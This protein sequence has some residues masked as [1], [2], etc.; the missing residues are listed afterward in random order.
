MCGLLLALQLQHLDLYFNV[1]LPSAP[2]QDDGSLAVESS[3]NC[4]QQLTYL[5]LDVPNL[6]VN[7]ST[8]P[9]PCN[10]PDLQHLDLRR[11]TWDPQ[12]LCTMSKLQDLSLDDLKV[13]T[14]AALSGSVGLQQLTQLVLGLSGLG[15]LSATACAALTASSC[16]HVV[17][18]SCSMPDGAWQ[19]IFAAGRSKPFLTKL[20]LCSRACPIGEDLCSLVQCCPALAELYLGRYGR[21]PGISLS[22]L[23]ALTS[24]THLSTVDNAVSEQSVCVL[25]QLPQLVKLSVYFHGQ[26]SDLSILQLTALRQV[27]SLELT[28]GC[29]DRAIL[30]RYLN[31]FVQVSG[32]GSAAITHDTAKPSR[33]VKFTIRFLLLETAMYAPLY[34]C[35]PSMLVTTRARAE[36]SG[37]CNK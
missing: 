19:H 8:M 13:T 27:T 25:A 32:R 26:C 12:L 31:H 34:V 5:K 35:L 10:L 33:F 7:S 1:G 11:V 30:T 22:P 28:S 17:D 24:L 9:A 21:I 3:H 20:C 29:S 4:L 18:I 2:A 15:E 6:K 16:L 37:A 14:E 36:Q 23:L